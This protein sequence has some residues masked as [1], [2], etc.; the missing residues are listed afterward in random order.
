MR[1]VSFFK[2]KFPLPHFYNQ[3][4]KVN[5][6]TWLRSNEKRKKYGP[7]KNTWYGNKPLKP[8]LRKGK[9]Q[10][11]KIKMQGKYRASCGVM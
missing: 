1:Q 6:I 4:T 9:Q 2:Q 5:T 8:A 10:E 11:G 3:A 7:T